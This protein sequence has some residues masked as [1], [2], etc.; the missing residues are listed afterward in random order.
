MDKQ[1]CKDC[2]NFMVR[3]ID[4]SNLSN[5]EFRRSARVVKA[6]NAYGVARVM[7]CKF[8]LTPQKYYIEGGVVNTLRVDSC[9]MC[10]PCDLVTS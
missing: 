3:T 7:R 8:E 10:D 6:I 9:S 1:R 4:S 2:M 5:T